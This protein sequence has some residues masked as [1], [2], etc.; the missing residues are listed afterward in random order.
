MRLRLFLLAITFSTGL[1]AQQFFQVQIVGSG[2]PMILIPGLSSSGK[3]WHSTV[4]HYRD[5]YECHVLTVAGFA[6]V[7]RV[8]GPMIEPVRE[9]IAAYIRENSLNNPVL[10]GHSLG[11]FW[12]LAV[13]SKHPERVGP[14]V[15]VDAYP[16]MAGLMDPHATPERAVASAAKM[17]EYMSQQSQ[18]MYERYVRSGLSTRPMVS[19]DSDLDTLIEWGLASD[20]SAVTDAMSEL[21][22][23]D[24]REDLSA[25][26][27]PALVLGA[28]IGYKQ[29]TDR[30]RTEA[31]LRRQSAKLA[32]VEIH[33]TDI[34]SH[35]IM[36][37]DP[38]WMF[39]HM[40][41]FL[42]AAEG[43]KSR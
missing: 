17:R 39:A 10:V 33:V 22:A 11:G 30:N 41:R 26:Q 43:T 38:D 36:W 34:A 14:I 31:N 35:F 3:V 8:E 40:D 12:A 1:L 13:A 28:W 37:D 42:S 27:S 32:G 19:K 7:P 15:I 24:L 6:G 16:F 5:R 18:D 29:Y 23:A 25:I 2:R 20:R 21:I 4:D 9:A